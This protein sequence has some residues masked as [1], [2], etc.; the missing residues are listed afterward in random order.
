M[1]IA[2]ETIAP[3]TIILNGTA[4]LVIYPSAMVPAYMVIALDPITARASIILNG[5]DLY[6]TYLSVM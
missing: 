5:L 3:V 4:L 6:A 1:V 2:A